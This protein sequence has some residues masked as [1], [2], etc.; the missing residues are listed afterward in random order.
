MK[1]LFTVDFFRHGAQYFIT[2]AQLWID[3]CTEHFVRHVVMRLEHVFPIIEFS[4]T[5]CIEKLRF[6]D[7]QSAGIHQRTAAHTHTR[8]NA[9]VFEKTQTHDA[10][11]FNRGNPQPTF[12]LPIGCGKVIRREPFALFDDQHFVTF[13]GQAQ[14]AD[15]TT[16]ATANHHVVIL[17]LQQL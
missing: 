13:F 3:L 8:Q 6:G 10:L 15:R 1:I 4:P 17:R 14:R 5:A 16:K 9:D 12:N 2:C 11:G 7:G